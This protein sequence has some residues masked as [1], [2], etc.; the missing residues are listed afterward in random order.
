MIRFNFKRFQIL[1]ALVLILSFSFS[2]LQ[3]VEELIKPKCVDGTIKYS[4]SA[5]LKDYLE[6]EKNIDG[7]PIFNSLSDIIRKKL[8]F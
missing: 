8:A 5:N 1:L 2:N 4:I 3:D 7:R 6:N